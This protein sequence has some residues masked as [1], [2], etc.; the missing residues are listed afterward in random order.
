MR[1]G[2]VSFAGYGVLF[3]LRRK[4]QGVFGCD[5]RRKGRGQVTGILRLT[6]G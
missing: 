1:F 2:I 6:A 3:L 4:G 5:S